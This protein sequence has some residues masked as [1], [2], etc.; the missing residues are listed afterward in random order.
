MTVEQVE[1]IDTIGIEKGTG[2]IVM[3][4]SDDLEWGEMSHLLTLQKKLNCY[5]DYVQGGQLLEAYPDAKERIIE[6]G[7]ICTHEPDAKGMEFLDN[8]S[9]VI[10][11]AGCQFQVGLMPSELRVEE[12]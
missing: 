8:C 11:E 3:T 1:K 12:T 5:L 6:I 4:I 2:K 7:L 10:E 9:K